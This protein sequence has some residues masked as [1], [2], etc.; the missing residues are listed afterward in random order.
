MTPRPFR[1]PI[2]VA[3]PLDVDEPQKPPKPRKPKG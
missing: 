1:W 2:P 3:V